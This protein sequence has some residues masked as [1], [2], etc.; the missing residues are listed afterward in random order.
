M[1]L[2]RDEFGSAVPARYDMLGELAFERVL[3]RLP[4]HRVATREG[5]GGGVD[6]PS[7]SEIDN[8]DGAVAIDEDVGGLE[9]AMNE[10]HALGCRVRPEATCM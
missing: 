4:H 6:L 3:V 1:V 8:L 5:L 7:Q 10:V 9:I 2:Q